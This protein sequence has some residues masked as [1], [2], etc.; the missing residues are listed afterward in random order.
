MENG[1]MDLGVF[2]VLHHIFVNFSIISAKKACGEEIRQ[3]TML[4]W[5]R[6]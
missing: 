6:L 3:A 5:Q 2:F 1:G 4:V